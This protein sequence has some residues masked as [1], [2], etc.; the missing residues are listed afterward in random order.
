M[1]VLAALGLALPLA[2]GG[3]FQTP[4][5][6]ALFGDFQSGGGHGGG[7]FATPTPT[8]GG[9]IPT[10]TPGGGGSGSGSISGTVSG[11]NGESV[12]IVAVST[13]TTNYGMTTRSGDGAYTITGLADDVYYVE[14]ASAS[15]AGIYNNGGTVTISGGNAVTGINITAY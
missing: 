10:P 15:Y 3:C 8:G 13:T 6:P 2:V 11:F 5:S 7:V 4:T 12:T 1:L 9:V 14:A